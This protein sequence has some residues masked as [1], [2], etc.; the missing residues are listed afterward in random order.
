MLKEK[1][2]KL[3]KEQGA[4][5]FDKFMSLSAVA[6][7][8]YYRNSNPLGLKGDFI[9]AP[10][11]SQVFGELIGLWLLDCWFKLGSPDKCFLV[12]LG[13]GRGTLMADILRATK[14]V[15]E[16]HDSLNIKIVEINQE[17]IHLQKSI[18]QDYTNISWVKSVEEIDVD[19]PVL[20]Y[21][22]EFFD[23]LPTKQYLLKENNCFELM[24]DI[25]KN[26]KLKLVFLKT[27]NYLLPKEIIP[28]DKEIIY[29]TSPMANSI[30]NY[31]SAIVAEFSGVILTIDYG[32]TTP[33]FRNSIR[34]YKNHKVLDVFEIINQVGEVDFTYNVNFKELHMAVN[35]LKIDKFKVITQKEFLENLGIHE[36]AS[37]L[38][39][40]IV[41]T[42][43][44]QDFI[45]QITTLI[46]PTQMGE[47][48][49][50]MCL[51]KN[52]KNLAI[53]EK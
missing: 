53:F 27:E 9:T 40:N 26:N 11:I 41:E 13:A 16:F 39:K 18:L 49:K 51:S 35:E 48:F 47:K 46:S 1:I 6:E 45:E 25:D 50:A 2:V 12:E 38:L 36:R 14:K 32:Y 28:T 10:E 52:I 19:A 7:E 23:S 21:S 15:K 29:E 42:K 34:G 31:L 17:L 24:V 44:K 5:P 8:G 33:E 20:I 30:F 22:N 4:I 3:I 37:I 43:D